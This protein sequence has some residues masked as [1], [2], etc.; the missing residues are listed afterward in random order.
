METG[1]ADLAA[2]LLARQVYAYEHSPQL[3][4]LLAERCTALQA[5]MD[6]HRR[7]GDAK[8]ADAVGHCAEC[9]HA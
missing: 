6:A 4:G 8:A 2:S 1:K 7:G 3:Q 9:P 5:L